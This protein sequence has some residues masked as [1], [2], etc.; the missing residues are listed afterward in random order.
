VDRRLL[1][2][3]ELRSRFEWRCNSDIMRPAWFHAQ[4]LRAVLRR[5]KICTMPELKA[6]LGTEVDV[7]VFRK[8][9]ELGY[10][11]SYSHRGGYYTLDEIAR[12]DARGLWSFDSV[13]FSRYRTLVSTVENFVKDSEAGYFARD[14]EGVLHVG[15]KEALL[16]LVREGRIVRQEVAGLYLYSASDRRRGKQ[17]LRARHVQEAEPRVTRSV[18]A[19][20]VLPDELKAAIVLFISQLDEKQRRLY[21]ALESLKFGQGG[22]RR[23]AELLGLDV[24]TVARG[25]HELV[26]RDFELERVRKPGAGRKPVEKKHRK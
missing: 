26:A 16:K 1:V 23:I 12:F 11:T 22:D 3:L 7:T 2:L 14:L 9:K 8:L 15:V 17:Q 5:H 19:S 6:A 20:R 24:G 10:R 4:D 25:R 21:A 18:A 13:W